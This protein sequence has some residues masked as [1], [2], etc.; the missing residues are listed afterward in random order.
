MEDRDFNPSRRDNGR[1][2]RRKGYLTQEEYLREVREN[3]QP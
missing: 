3:N 2:R 1:S